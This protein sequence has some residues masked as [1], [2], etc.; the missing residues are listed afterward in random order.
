MIG[1]VLLLFGRMKVF[2]AQK[3]YLNTICK[4]EESIAVSP[5]ILETK[6]SGHSPEME[7]TYTEVLLSAGTV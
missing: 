1:E 6:A 3:V 7:E 2:V 5:D 4:M